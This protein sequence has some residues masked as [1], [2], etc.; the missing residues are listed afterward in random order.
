MIASKQLSVL[1]SIASSDHYV[2]VAIIRKLVQH[3]AF[4]VVCLSLNVAS[5]HSQSA[6]WSITY[7]K[8]PVENDER[9]HYPLALLELALKKTGVS[10]E[11]NPSVSP[12]RQ[13]RAI[14]RLEEN[15]EINVFWSMTD[16]ER[17]EDLR[18]IRIPIAKGL[19]GWRVLLTHTN[20]KFK[21]AEINSLDDLLTFSPVQGLSWP[22]T[23]IL[24][25]NGF[26]VVTSRDYVEATSILT[27]QLADFFPR[28][29]TEVTE[30]LNNLYSNNF[31][32]KEGV[33]IHYP[34]ALYFFTN[35][36]NV[37]LARLIE[38]GLHRA[39]D[40]GSFDELFQQYFGETLAKL[41][42]ENSLR[43][44]LTNPLLPLHTPLSNEKY[45]YRPI[46]N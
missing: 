29:V 30:E 17:E 33:V 36:R 22:D 28:S 31:T 32:I 34:T 4:L 24:Q 16:I 3:F 35:K 5:F 19:I 12:M 45:W 10:Y 13:A 21:N 40:D 25:A 37:T 39:I 7:P 18:P 11:L 26:N 44:E 2:D 42:I 6:V 38:T 14:K 43:F 23:K 1:Q 20:N 8:S 46:S 27:N 9:T 15:L 41:D